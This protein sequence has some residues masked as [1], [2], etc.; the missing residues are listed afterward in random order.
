MEVGIEKWLFGVLMVANLCLGLYFSFVSRA[1]SASTP[2]EVFLGSRTLKV[3]PLAVSVLAS[4]FSAIGVIGFCAH[5]YA[6]GFHYIWGVLAFP[7]LIPVVAGVIIPLLYRLGVT[8]VFQ[9]R[10]RGG[11][12]V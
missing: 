1:R 5:Y 4:M 7:L 8:S 9:V 3:L 11:L 6:Y 2:E 12:H 10:F